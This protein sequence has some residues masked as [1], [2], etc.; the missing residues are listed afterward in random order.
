[1]TARSV[2]YL[3]LATI[4]AFAIGFG[5][6]FFWVPN[7]ADQG[8]IQKIFYLHVPLA[9]VALVGFIVGGIHGLRYLTT[10]DANHDVRSYIAIHISVIFAVGV[11]ITGAIWG[12]GAWGKWW[13]WEEPTLVSFLIVAL[14]YCTYYPLRFAIEDRE[15]QARYAS[16]FAVMAGAFVPLNFAAV[17]MAESF[18]HPRTLA[19]A[20]GGLPGSMK[21]TVLVCGIAMALLWVTLARTELLIKTT[22]WRMRRL[23]R[24]LGEAGAAGRPSRVAPVVPPTEVGSD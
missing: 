2:L 3:A 12:K 9:I 6:V 23:E 1:M 11:L 8:F 13:V 4:A 14:L 16:L 15:R 20:E 19:T 7:E 21:L 22:R 18:L 5:L 17:R 24:E 10:R